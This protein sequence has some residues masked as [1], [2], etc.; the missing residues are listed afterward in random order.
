MVK[1]I[2]DNIFLETYQN[3]Y[4]IIKNELENHFENKR[5]LEIPVIDNNKNFIKSKISFLSPSLI[6]SVLNYK[7]L[8]KNRLS[9]LYGLIKLKSLNTKKEKN[10]IFILVKTK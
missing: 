10:S 8:L 3:F 9:V 6:S 2:L 1:L 7:S 5:N 4:K